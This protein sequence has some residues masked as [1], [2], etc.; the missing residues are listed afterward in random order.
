M[1]DWYDPTQFTIREMTFSTTE[2]SNPSKS[3]LQD[4]IESVVRVDLVSWHITGVST[5]LGIPDVDFLNVSFSGV[6]LVNGV[7]D[8]GGDF[9]FR[10]TPTAEV[11]KADFDNRIVKMVGK[12]SQMRF[13][14]VG[15]IV[16][17]ANGGRVDPSTY[18]VITFVFRLFSYTKAA[19]L[20]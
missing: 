14:D 4:K 17:D 20:N 12:D 16:T 8:K 13:R 9:G 1:V 15:V 19:M 11:T 10:I 5:S 7:A 2:G 6:E 18:G 3:R